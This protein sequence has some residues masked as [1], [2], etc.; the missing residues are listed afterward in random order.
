[1]P[2]LSDYEHRPLAAVTSQVTAYKK[3]GPQPSFEGLGKKNA[4]G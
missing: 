2:S 3:L 1:M 4:P